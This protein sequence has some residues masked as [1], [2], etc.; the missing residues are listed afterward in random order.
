MVPVLHMGKLRLGEGKAAAQGPR[1][2]TPCSGPSPEPLDPS[3][4]PSSSPPLPRSLALC[5]DISQGSQLVLYVQVQDEPLP[6][7]CPFPHWLIFGRAGRSCLHVQFPIRDFSVNLISYFR[8]QEGED[9]LRIFQ[10]LCEG[11]VRK[12][13]SVL[14]FH[15]TLAT[16]SFFG[17]TPTLQ[18]LT[19]GL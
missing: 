17:I 2:S 16:T 5:Q 8:A 7:S 9:C 15:S 6:C 10:G 11:N 12:V 18:L 4:C 3:S 1:S 13:S 14:P 19:K